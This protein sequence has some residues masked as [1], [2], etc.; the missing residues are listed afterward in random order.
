MSKKIGDYARC[1]PSI[2]PR[3]KTDFETAR[4]VLLVARR[5]YGGINREIAQSRM[6]GARITWSWVRAPR[7]SG[8]L[9]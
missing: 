3:A 7:A 1:T 5:A 2:A 9:E 6:R 8:L 4:R